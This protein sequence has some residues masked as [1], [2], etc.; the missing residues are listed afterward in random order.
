[1]APVGGAEELLVLRPGKAKA[2]KRVKNKKAEEGEGERAKHA[3][4]SSC[5]SWL[6]KLARDYGGEVTYL[7]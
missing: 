1:M 3:R 6:G 2:K 7:A 5:S 4:L